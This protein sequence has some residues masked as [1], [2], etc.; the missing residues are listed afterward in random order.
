MVNKIYLL[1]ANIISEMT[2]LYPNEKVLR[3]IEMHE[4]FSAISSLTWFELLNG[5]KQ[6]EKG[7][8][9]SHEGFHD[10]FCGYSQQYDFSHKKRKRF[11]LHKEKI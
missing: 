10:S 1:D 11:F 2:S 6:L 9:T 3:N 8:N 7:K 4:D 5:M